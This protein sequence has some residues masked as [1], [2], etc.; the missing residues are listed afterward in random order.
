MTGER[1]TDFRCDVR[2]VVLSLPWSA[3]FVGETFGTG[4]WEGTPEDTA[5]LSVSGAC[6]YDADTARGALAGALASVAYRYGQEAVYLLVG[7]GMLVSR[8]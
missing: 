4:E 2:G 6:G 8:A 1:W 7:P 5:S 3:P